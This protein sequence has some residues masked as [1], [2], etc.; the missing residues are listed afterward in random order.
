MLYSDQILY[1]NA[2]YSFVRTRHDKVKIMQQSVSRGWKMCDCNELS[3]HGA[4]SR[5]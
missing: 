1:N 2:I 5:L 4:E 3:D